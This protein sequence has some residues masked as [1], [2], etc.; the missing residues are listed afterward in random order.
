M[1]SEGI[2]VVLL[3]GQPVDVDLSRATTMLALQQ[4]IASS[5][6][7]QDATGVQLIQGGQVLGDGT[8]M[9]LDTANGQ[10]T[11]VLQSGVDWSKVELKTS[12]ESECDEGTCYC[13]AC[14]VLH[15][16][17]VEL[18]S[19]S[20]SSTSNIGGA[21]GDDHDAKLS[22]DKNTLTVVKKSVTRSLGCPR[23]D[24]SETTVLLV[25]DLVLK[26]RESGRL[27]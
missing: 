4:T 7:L 9:P 27:Q 1:A 15:Y 22:D 5:L 14:S 10:L 16:D 13:S 18:W 12:R 21:R 17:G 20:T 6:K 19:F 24:E 23:P 25:A 11:V 3:S 26:A 8:T 2:K